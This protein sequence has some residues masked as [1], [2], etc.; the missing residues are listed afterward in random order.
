MN[1]LIAN[2]LSPQRQ[3]ITAEITQVIQNHQSR[4]DAL[5]AFAS[6]SPAF[7][8]KSTCDLISGNSLSQS[9]E[10]SRK[11][12]E[13]HAEFLAYLEKL[14]GPRMTLAVEDLQKMPVFLPVPADRTILWE[15]LRTNVMTLAVW[16]AV[17]F[18]IGWIGFRSRVH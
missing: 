12:G 1:S 6:W 9:I 10:F 18:L 15:R 16:S 3:R 13:F 7:A 11:T 2:E 14:P 4:S 17:P 8:I 5:D